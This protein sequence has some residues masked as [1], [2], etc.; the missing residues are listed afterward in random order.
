M[1]Y[2]RACKP[3]PMSGS[4]TMTISTNHVALCDLVQH[5]LPAVVAEPLGD[6]EVLVPKMVKLED[7]RVCLAAIDA[8]P[9]AE[10]FH[11][12]GSALHRNRSLAPQRVGYIALTVCGVVL[13][14]VVGSAWAAVVVQL[15]A[16]LAS[17]CELGGGLELPAASAAPRRFASYVHERMFP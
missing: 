11:E 7:E 4:P 8:R 6:I 15:P 3:G 1:S 16:R 14:L 12:T 9:L 5:G 2:H 10:E 13:L 17:P